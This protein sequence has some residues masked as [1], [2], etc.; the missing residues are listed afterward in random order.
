MPHP[1][2]KKITLYASLGFLVL[3]IFFAIK[4]YLTVL[5]P[6]TNFESEEAFVYVPTNANYE[7]VKES[8]LPLVKDWDTFDAWAQQQNYPIKI[9]S[10]KF[11]L[12]KGMTNFQIYLALRKSVP[13]KVTFNNIERLENFASR[14]S[15]LIEADSASIV[16]AFQNEKFLL[17]HQLTKE[18]AFTLLLPNTYEFYWDTPA[19]KFREK[20]S[21]EYWKF[22]NGTRAEQAKTLGLTPAQVTTLASIVHKESVK[23]DERPRIAGVYL[24][25][26]QKGMPLQADPTVIFAYKLQ[27]QNFEEE[28]KRVTANLLQTNSAYNTYRNNGLPPGPIFMPDV[29]AIDAVLNPEQHNYM[30]FCASTTRF[31]YHDFAVTY[32][33]HQK[34]AKNYQAWLQNQ[35]ITK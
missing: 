4:I 27:N 11:R 14:I 18:E 26:L 1:G 5:V 29:S 28:I 16:E 10:G 23:A 7:T 17:E 30:Y 34:N 31:G 24:N 22:W 33:E 35:G 20:M 9:K 13:V 6:N 21:K 15:K 19:S 3:F 8:L 32:A 2:L 25:R 12:E